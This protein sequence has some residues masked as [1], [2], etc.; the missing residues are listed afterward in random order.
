MLK[1][2]DGYANFDSVTPIQPT[3]F[4]PESGAGY[5][6]LVKLNRPVSI[7]EACDLIK[8]HF[9]LKFGN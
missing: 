9:G 4:D 5:G 6:R 8:S 7:T 2:F 3:K 1:A